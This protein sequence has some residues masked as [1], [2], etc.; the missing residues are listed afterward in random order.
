VVI[1][2]ISLNENDKSSNSSDNEN[3]N[4]DSENLSLLDVEIMSEKNKNYYLSFCSICWLYIP[5]FIQKVN[6]LFYIFYKCN[7]RFN[8]LQLS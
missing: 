6:T 3:E 4:A 8:D 7:I 1:F 2:F 5:V